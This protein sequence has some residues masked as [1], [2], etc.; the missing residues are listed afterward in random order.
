MEHVS[1]LLLL[2]YKEHK[3]IEDFGLVNCLKVIVF[4]VIRNSAS[5]LKFYYDWNGQLKIVKEIRHHSHL[6]IEIQTLHSK[7]QILFMRRSRIIVT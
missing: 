3:R 7:F 4:V 6:K 2:K 5:A 1:A